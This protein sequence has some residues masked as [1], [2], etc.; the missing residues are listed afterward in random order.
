MFCSVDQKRNQGRLIPSVKSCE[1][2]V[3]VH[4][5]ST[6]C[7]MRYTKDN[8]LLIELVVLAQK[9]AFS[10]VLFIHITVAFR[11]ICKRKISARAVVQ[12]LASGCAKIHVVLH[13]RFCSSLYDPPFASGCANSYAVGKYP[14]TFGF[15]FRLFIC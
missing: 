6:Y 1:F 15:S 9:W 11:T 7:C 10:L 12:M 8:R 4:R 5:V 3:G 13:G 14:N 2:A